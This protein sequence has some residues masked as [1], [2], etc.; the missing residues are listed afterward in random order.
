MREPNNNH[1]DAPPRGDR[2]RLV[3]AAVV[4]ST[5]LVIL[6]LGLFSAHYSG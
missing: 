3:Y 1:D 6:L 4:A 2:W 5:L